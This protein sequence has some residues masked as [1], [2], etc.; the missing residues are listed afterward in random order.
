M[1]YTDVDQ[2]A[3][4]HLV[5]LEDLRQLVDALTQALGCRVVIQ[6]TE[7]NTLLTSGRTIRGGHDVI[8]PIVDMEH[9]GS[10]GQLILTTPSGKSRA[11]ARAT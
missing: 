11:M 9:L 2:L 7:A 6:D 3:L 8:L 10:F 1:N 4:R 5:S